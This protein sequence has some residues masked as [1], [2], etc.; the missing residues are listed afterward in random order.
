MGLVASF[1][2]R[3]VHRRDVDVGEVEREL[4][5]AVLLDVPTN[6]LDGL[7]GAGD[8]NG[9]TMLVKDGWTGDAVT[10]LDATSLSDVKRNG[11]RPTA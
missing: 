11:V 7:E 2:K 4:G 10:L 6:A 3:H 8:A 5:D 9:L 1:V